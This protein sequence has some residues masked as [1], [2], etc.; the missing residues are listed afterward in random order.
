MPISNY[1][2]LTTA[3]ASWLDVSS[4]D[5]SA[6]V[7]DLVTMGEN[8]IFRELRTKDMEAS[9]NATI[10]SGVISLPS[11]FVELKYA[12]I[13]GSPTQYLESRPSAWIYERYPTRSS[14]GVPAF[15]A[16]DGTNFIFGP[17][18]DSNYTVKGTYYK[19]MAAIQSSASALVTSYPD[20]YLMA[21][22]A[23]SEPL[24]G[25]DKRI[26]IWESKYRMMRDAIMTEDSNGRFGGPLSVR[27]G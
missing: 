10:S 17:Y 15:I 8:R 1:T 19:R 14:T 27:V 21:C 3:L 5:I 11:D 7:S 16:R 9:L 4:S 2:S 6:V 24:I 26:P 22:L 13:D 23:E 20:L 18:P 25:R 12:Y